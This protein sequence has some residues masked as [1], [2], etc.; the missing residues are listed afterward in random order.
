MQP[1]KTL[2]NA[3]STDA[4]IWISNVQSGFL[5][6]EMCSYYSEYDHLLWS[7]CIRYGSMIYCT[8]Q[9]N[10]RILSPPHC[11]QKVTYDNRQLWQCEEQRLTLLQSIRTRHYSNQVKI[12]YFG[13]SHMILHLQA[14]FTKMRCHLIEIEFEH[15]GTSHMTVTQPDEHAR[16]ITCQGEVEGYV[17]LKEGHLQMKQK[18]NQIL[19]QSQWVCNYATT[20]P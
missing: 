4:I 1:T 5:T 8:H 3:K 6:E 18:P 14:Q 10:C 9:C 13:M 11:H 19:C 12:R 7:W 17:Q 15:I 2:R 20:K 16:V